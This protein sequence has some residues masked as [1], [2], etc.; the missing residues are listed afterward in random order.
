MI[1]RLSGRL[2][3]AQ[4]DFQNTEKLLNPQTIKYKDVKK[5]D[6]CMKSIISDDRFWLN[7]HS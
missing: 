7:L 1:C 6:S 2:G 3:D 4:T 5:N